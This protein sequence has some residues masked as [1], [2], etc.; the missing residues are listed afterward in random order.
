MPSLIAQLGG[1][2]QNRNIVCLCAPGS[3]KY[4]AGFGMKGGGH[5]LPCIIYIPFGFPAKGMDA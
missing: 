5:S 1:G 4:L 2:A 3:E